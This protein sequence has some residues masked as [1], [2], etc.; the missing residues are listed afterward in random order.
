MASIT[1]RTKS[2]YWTACYTCSDGRQLKRSTKTTDKRQALQFALELE[3]AERKAA[4]GTVTTIQLRKVLSDFSERVTG[5]TLHAPSIESYLKD[6][7]KSI[8]SRNRAATILRYDKT[9]RL[10]VES[11][12]GKASQPI[13][14]LTPKDIE[15]FLT[16]RLETGVAPQTATIDLKTL[17]TAFRRAEAYG[18]ILKNPVAVVRP[19]KENRSEREIFT[20]EEVQKLINSAPSLDWQ[21]LI[22]LGR[23]HEHTDDDGV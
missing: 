12:N 22:L 11:L 14:A 20:H 18:M 5:D 19:P 3:H 21:T 4:S 7:L 10:F 9:V 15:A 2:K 8:K 13:T 23:S 6:W 1:R 16:K 17:N